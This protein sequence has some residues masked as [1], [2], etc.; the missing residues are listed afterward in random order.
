[1][2]PTLTMELNV[3]GGDID[4]SNLSEKEKLLT[5][6]THTSTYFK[7]SFVSILL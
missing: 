4:S 1:M 5:F 2:Q 6:S 7:Q 3:S